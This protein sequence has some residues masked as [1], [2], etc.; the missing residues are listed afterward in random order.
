MTLP[1]AF[2]HRDGDR[3]VPTALCAGPWS[4]EHQH[5]GPP[6]ALLAGA[7][8]RFGDPGFFLARLTV[9]LLRPVPMA[10]LRVVVAPVAQGR[11]VERVEARLLAGEGVVV[12]ALGLRIRRA[13][14]A[15]P[16]RPEPRLPGP[17]GAPEA[18]F[19]FFP[20]EVAYHRAVEV[21][22]VRGTWGDGPVTG[23]MR[24]RVP[25]VAGEV[26][27]PW[28][29]VACVADAESGLCPPLAP[30]RFAFPNPD[31]C[32]T[33]DRPPAG[34][35]VGLDARSTARPD[36]IGLA[37]SALYDLDGPIGRSVQTLVVRARG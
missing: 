19:T 14:V 6:T 30:E 28:E 17:E 26:P 1:E 22:I 16:D 25:L 21:R 18:P 10:P 29:R 3:F 9:E 27:R 31:L 15:V 24:P 34:E 8:D 33:L 20:Q 11:S 13:P 5:G 36:G 12:T 7:L 35:W 37:E 32:I 23:W 2:F 4:A